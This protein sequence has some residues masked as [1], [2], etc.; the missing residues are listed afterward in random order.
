MYILLLIAVLGLGAWIL[1]HGVLGRSRLRA[2]AGICVGLAGVG[3][4]AFASFWG[5]LLWF[6]SLG[7]GA[8]FWKM[9]GARVGAFAFGVLAGGVG[10]ALLSRSRDSARSWVSRLWP[11]L[12]G[13]L[14]GALWGLESWNEILL[15]AHRVSTGLVDPILGRDTGFYLFVLPLLDQLFWLAAWIAGVALLA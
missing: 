9:V 10:V 7:Q 5:E 11:I 1:S 6:E 8:R 13:S 3:L 14:G 12:L 2:A 15:Y 4:F